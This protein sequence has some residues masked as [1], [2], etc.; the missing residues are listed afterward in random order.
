MLVNIENIATRRMRWE[1]ELMVPFQK[2]ANKQRVVTRVEASRTAL[3][4][5]NL[6]NLKKMNKTYQNINN[7]QR[8]TKWKPKPTTDTTNISECRSDLGV[9]WRQ[10]FDAP[11]LSQALHVL[12]E[13]FDA[14]T[15]S[16]VTSIILKLVL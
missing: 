6:T 3:H 1:M 5:L 7:V 11:N 2:W 8:K 14:D 12:N 10:E 16:I 15:C 9:K 4:V 13:A